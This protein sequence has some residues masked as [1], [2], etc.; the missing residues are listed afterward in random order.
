MFHPILRNFCGT[1]LAG[2]Q[3]G[4]NERQSQPQNGCLVQFLTAHSV[5]FERSRPPRQLAGL[6]QTRKGYG[7][8]YTRSM[9]ARADLSGAAEVPEE[10]T[11]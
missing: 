7:S 1:T 3:Q 2:T 11:G 9:G 5:D 10:P 6:L 8:D 4:S